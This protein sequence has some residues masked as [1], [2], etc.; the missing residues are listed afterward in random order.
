[1]RTYHLPSIVYIDTSALLETWKLQ[2]FI[3]KHE[4]SGDFTVV[5]LKEVYLELLRLSKCDEEW[6]RRHAREAIQL[7]NGS[8]IFEKEVADGRIWTIEEE[9]QAFADKRILAELTMNKPDHCQTVITGDWKLSRDI[10]NLNSQES[11]YGGVIKAV[12]ISDDG[13]LLPYVQ[14]AQQC[15]V[16]NIPVINSVHT[17]RAE[18]VR[19]HHELDASISFENDQRRSNIWRSIGKAALLDMGQLHFQ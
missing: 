14:V 17:E 4:S 6:K 1:M 11:V 16:D 5:I 7:S 10:L 18:E 9:K 8:D 3:T 13:A 19:V 15:S 12:C 2:Q